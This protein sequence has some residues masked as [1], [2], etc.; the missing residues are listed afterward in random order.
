[1]M[2]KLLSLFLFAADKPP[3]KASEVNIPN[4]SADDVALAALA[5]VYWVTG[6]AA[7][8]VIIIGGIIYA[9]SDGNPQRVERGRKAITYSIVGLVVILSAFVI[10]NFVVGR[11]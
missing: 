7:V 5:I 1:M 2:D 10:T 4:T 9:T 11:F 8:I 3:L 6:V